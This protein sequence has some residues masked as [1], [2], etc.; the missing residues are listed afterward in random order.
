MQTLQGTH[1]PGL[2][3]RCWHRCC[4]VVTFLWK[5]FLHLRLYEPGACSVLELFSIFS[6]VFYLTVIL[7]LPDWII[8]KVAEVWK[9]FSS[10]IANNGL[11]VWRQYWKGGWHVV[12][13]SPEQWFQACR[14]APQSRVGSV[15]RIVVC[16]VGFLLFWEV[17]VHVCILNIS[18]FLFPE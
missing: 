11:R 6:L 17:T 10:R 18:V 7:W 5:G 16:T 3:E 8:E 14:Y 15:L 9:H 12:G 1:L 4:L 13:M 2:R